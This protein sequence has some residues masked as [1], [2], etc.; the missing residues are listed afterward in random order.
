MGS[1]YAI[2]ELV[3]TTP[4]LD[5]KGVD[6]FS[7]PHGSLAGSLPAWISWFQPKLEYDIGSIVY[8][9][10]DSSGNPQKLKID[11]DITVTSTQSGGDLRGGSMVQAAGSHNVNSQNWYFDYDKSHLYV[12]IHGDGR[13][14]SDSDFQVATNRW[15]KGWYSFSELEDSAIWGGSWETGFGSK[16]AGLDGS[17]NLSNVNINS[18]QVF[19]NLTDVFADLKNTSKWVYCNSVLT[20]PDPKPDSWPVAV[21]HEQIAVIPIDKVTIGGNVVRTPFMHGNNLI[22]SGDYPPWAI[23][24]DQSDNSNP[25]RAKLSNTYIPTFDPRY[26][27]GRSSLNAWLGAQYTYAR[28]STSV[29]SKPHWATGVNY[30]AGE[31]VRQKS[32]SGQPDDESARTT[33]DVLWICLAPH[34][35][36]TENA[37]PYYDDAGANWNGDLWR[38]YSTFINRP[39]SS[40]GDLWKG[41][42]SAGA[43]GKLGISAGTGISMSGEGPPGE[44]R[45]R[46]SDMIGG[47]RLYGH[48]TICPGKQTQQ[49]HYR[50]RNSWGRRRTVTFNFPPNSEAT[51]AKVDLW[52]FPNNFKKDHGGS[53]SYAVHFVDKSNYYIRRAKRRGFWSRF[54]LGLFGKTR[55]EHVYQDG[56]FT[57]S[58]FQTLAGESNYKIGERDPSQ[59]VWFGQ[60]DL[61][62][63]QNRTV[64]TAVAPESDILRFSFA[65]LV[66]DHYES[67]HGNTIS[68]DGEYAFIIQDLNA[69]TLCRPHFKY[70]D[71]SAT[72]ARSEADDGFGLPFVPSD[73]GKYSP[74]KWTQY[75]AAANAIV[76]F[77]SGSVNTGADLKLLA[78]RNYFNYL[79]LGPDISNLDDPIKPITVWSMDLSADQFEHICGLVQTGFRKINLQDLNADAASEAIWDGLPAFDDTIKSSGTTES[80]HKGPLDFEGYVNYWPDLLAFYNNGQNWDYGNGILVPANTKTIAEFGESHWFRHG[81][82]ELRHFPGAEAGQ[83]LIGNDINKMPVDFT[84]KISG[85][86]PGYDSQKSY[87]GGSIVSHSGKSWFAKRGS[88]GQA[89]TEGA[90]WKELT[91]SSYSIAEADSL[92]PTLTLARSWQKILESTYTAEPSGG[93]GRTG[94][95]IV[96]GRKLDFSFIWKEGVH[97]SC[98]PY[99]FLGLGQYAPDFDH[100]NIENYKKGMVVEIWD[101]MQS[102]QDEITDTI[103]DPTAQATALAKVRPRY[104]LFRMKKDWDPDSRTGGI[105]GLK[106][107][108]DWEFVV[109]SSTDAEAEYFN[110]QNEIVST[111][112]PQW[113][114]EWDSGSVYNLNDLVYTKKAPE[115]G[116]IGGVSADLYLVYRCTGSNITAEPM[117]SDAP[118]TSTPDYTKSIPKDTAYWEC[119]SD[120]QGAS[121]ATSVGK[122]L[123][124]E[125]IQ[126][127][128][129]G[130]FKVYGYTAKDFN[131]SLRFLLANNVV[132]DPN[133]ESNLLLDTEIVTSKAIFGKIPK[134]ATL[135]VSNGGT[136][137]NN[138]Q[139]TKNQWAVTTHDNPIIQEFLRSSESLGGTSWGEWL[140]DDNKAS[141]VTLTAGNELGL[142]SVTPGLQLG[143]PD[144]RLSSETF[145]DS[146]FLDNYSRPRDDI[147]RHR[148]AAIPFYA[149]VFD[150]VDLYVSSITKGGQKYSGITNAD[151]R[152]TTEIP[153]INAGTDGP[154]LLDQNKSSI[155]NDGVSDAILSWKAKDDADEGVSLMVSAPEC[156]SNAI[157]IGVNS[158]YTKIG[159]ITYPEV[160]DI[161]Y[162]KEI[163]FLC[164][165]GD[166]RS[167]VTNFINGSI[168]SSTTNQID[169]SDFNVSWPGI[170]DMVNRFKELYEGD[171]DVLTGP[172]AS[173]VVD[174]SPV[175]GN[176]YDINGLGLLLS[177]VDSTSL[178]VASNLGGVTNL[179]EVSTDASPITIVSQPLLDLKNYL[180]NA[181]T[182]GFCFSKNASLNDDLSD[183]MGAVIPAAELSVQS[184]VS[185]LVDK[186]KVFS[187]FFS[188]D[189]NSPLSTVSFGL[190]AGN[191]AGSLS[192]FQEL[193]GKELSICL[194]D[195][196]TDD[197]DAGNFGEYVDYWPD[198]LAYYNNGQP[199]D[200]GNGILVPAD[201]KTQAE[202]GESHWRAAGN[203]GG[204][205]NPPEYRYCPGMPGM[206]ELTAPVKLVDPPEP[207]FQNCPNYIEQLNLFVF[208]Y[209]D[210]EATRALWRATTTQTPHDEPTHVRN[211]AWWDSY[212]S[213]TADQLGN[214]FYRRETISGP[215]YGKVMDF[216][217]VDFVFPT[218]SGLNGDDGP[219]V[220]IKSEA[221]FRN[222]TASISQSPRTWQELTHKR[223]NIEDFGTL[224]IYPP[225][226][227][228]GSSQ[229]RTGNQK[230]ANGGDMADLTGGAYFAFESQAWF[231]LKVSDNLLSSTTKHK[232]FLIMNSWKHPLGVPALEYS[233]EKTTAAGGPNFSSLTSGLGSNWRHIPE[234]NGNIF[235]SSSGYYVYKSIPDGLDFKCLSPKFN[236]PSVLLENSEEFDALDRFHHNT[237]VVHDPNFET[238]LSSKLNQL[239]FSTIGEYFK[240]KIEFS[241]NGANSPTFV[242]FDPSR[243]DLLHNNQSGDP[244]LFQY[245]ID[246]D[247]FPSHGTLP[248]WTVS[249]GTGVPVGTQ[250]LQNTSLGGEVVEIDPPTVSSLSCEFIAPLEWTE[251]GVDTDA[252][253]H[254]DDEGWVYD[255][256]QNPKVALDAALTPE[257]IS[258]LASGFDSTDRIQ[259]LRSF[260]YTHFKV[261]FG[262]S[263]RIKNYS[264]PELVELLFK[265]SYTRVD[266]QYKSWMVKPGSKGWG[267][268]EPIKGGDDDHNSVIDWTWMFWRNVRSSFSDGTFPAG[269]DST[270]TDLHSAWEATGSKL[271]DRDTSYSPGDIVKRSNVGEDA[272][273]LHV[274]QLLPG[275]FDPS[276]AW[277]VYWMEKH[278]SSG[279]RIGGYKVLSDDNSDEY[280][281]LLTH[282]LFAPAE[283][284]NK[285]WYGL[286]NGFWEYVTG[287]VQDSDVADSSV[288]FSYSSDYDN[289]GWVFGSE[290]TISV[291]HEPWE[292]RLELKAGSSYKKYRSVSNPG[293]TCSIA[294]QYTQSACEAATSGGVNGVW[295]GG[296]DFKGSDRESMSKAGSI[297]FSI[298]Y[299][300]WK[301][302]AHYDDFEIRVSIC[303]CIHSYR[304]VDDLFVWKGIK[305]YTITNG[306]PEEDGGAYLADDFKSH[307]SW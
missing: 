153:D 31:A 270:W 62:N 59:S 35:S 210:D 130:N 168:A 226:A 167:Q 32:E 111:P 129:S 173:S 100:N 89:P 180:A 267:F 303:D 272:K 48:L 166:A 119:L 141:K 194:F 225:F 260:P 134:P 37:P 34:Q 230:N 171:K 214:W 146:E 131:N 253:N 143:V 50:D 294:G 58:H 70:R 251:L 274:C 175:D 21:E 40:V 297:N 212:G 276:H 259:Y 271:W 289:F 256:A 232:A 198:L 66:P 124:S 64:D 236:I 165:R 145:L 228:T 144:S 108:N 284:S 36:T 45:I 33:K 16:S 5:D 72:S 295:T 155:R 278:D 12:L 164:A 67:K 20:P 88:T 201:T 192:S 112:P 138:N 221:E 191:L 233:A 216:I 29:T 288:S 223:S 120:F 10:Y 86:A 8:A 268:I 22:V 249:D 219:S 63:A 77:D 169:G 202:F 254:I 99:F 39:N 6:I 209:Q 68:I 73:Y 7:G 240:S 255:L 79:L 207:N 42:K 197:L 262:E 76:N 56:A 87:E 269:H 82:G 154:L 90:Y 200:Y 85:S 176:T 242:G 151:K 95:F 298:P 279:N 203:A 305:P 160:H 199:W 126:S 122:G 54:F 307:S 222:A 28:P 17:G 159:Y 286:G 4:V 291:G 261:A 109:T 133:E 80:D 263:N 97:A 246:K 91:G 244:T 139:L 107:E 13:L 206:K 83:F 47:S 243:G 149:K 78:T 69:G 304:G 41:F 163:S 296:N 84:S 282:A 24:D 188:G 213:H 61:V 11:Q 157:D 55:K 18:T 234:S 239:G 275:S 170:T 118:W 123:Y 106:V 60:K 57:R 174:E 71:I 250:V 156:M 185:V 161:A 19:L 113:R 23:P 220:V 1:G 3:E 147:V 273:W 196:I 116:S 44:A 237:G 27:E 46:M 285:G 252:G 190:S 193:E 51:G 257:T 74:D 283:G 26:G 302:F 92:S 277:K 38:P 229:G 105:P 65:Q 162:K 184:R 178:A 9:L 179:S 182:L 177:I 110:V 30:E 43:I 135:L 136:W 292:L 121:P 93:G 245:K 189:S 75:T 187:K 293:G 217:E 195:G 301:Q 235:G 158:D 94:Q 132:R 208:H 231:Q 224:P 148:G 53:I 103:T 265:P 227:F 205:G 299:S 266:P 241:S 300:E 211:G 215:V 281:R 14:E 128:Y 25:A 258:R 101:F 142:C 49:K 183:L 114:A 264:I 98:L 238:E 218:D 125:A 204:F 290:G 181:G 115:A 306:A 127:Y 186:G 15:D 287:T 104:M 117:I 137:P 96:E 140:N 172:W 247:W 150:A 248:E 280:Q 81:T 52:L 102:L 152:L 2:D